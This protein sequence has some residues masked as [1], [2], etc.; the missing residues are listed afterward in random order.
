MAITKKALNA[1]LADVRAKADEKQKDA[2]QANY[3]DDKGAASSRTVPCNDGLAGTVLPR[4]TFDQERTVSNCK[5]EC[6]NRDKV[7]PGFEINDCPNM[8]EVEGDLSMDREHYKCDVCGK[9]DYLDYEEM[10]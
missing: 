9:R 8:K 4:L 6:V 5:G 2:Q 3:R 7:K 10:K 1:A